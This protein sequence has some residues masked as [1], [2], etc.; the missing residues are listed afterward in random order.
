MDKHDDFAL[1]VPQV[2]FSI[3]LANGY[4]ECVDRMATDDL[5]QWH[6]GN[7][8]QTDTPLACQLATVEAPFNR[9]RCIIGCHHL[10][11]GSE[12]GK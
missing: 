11:V 4:E 5:R 2:V 6:C 8:N 1:D 7:V 9:E 12:M 3:E 10:N